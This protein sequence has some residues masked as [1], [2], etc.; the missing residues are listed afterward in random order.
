M[1]TFTKGQKGNG[2]K[3]KHDTEDNKLIFFVI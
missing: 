1:E 2:E 3:C